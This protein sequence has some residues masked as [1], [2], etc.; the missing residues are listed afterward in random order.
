MAELIEKKRLANG[1]IAEFHDRSRRIAGDRW[2][3]G[4]TASVPVTLTRADFEDMENAE[5][6]YREFIRTRGKTVCFK[7]EK[8]RNFIDEREREKVFRQ[9]LSDLREHALRYMEHPSFAS[10]IKQ[11]EIKEFVEKRKWWKTTS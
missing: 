2:Y 6:I 3:V 11:K 5:E 8:E 10:G 1:L 7:M 4:L 9:L